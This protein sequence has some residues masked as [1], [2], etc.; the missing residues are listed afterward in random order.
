MVLDNIEPFAYRRDVLARLPS[1]PISQLPELLPDRWG[2][3][4]NLPEPPR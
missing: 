4:A 3:K 1:T 2:P